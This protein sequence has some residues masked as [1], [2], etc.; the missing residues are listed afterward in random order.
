M[1]AHLAMIDS[2]VCRTVITGGL[3][4]ENTKADIEKLLKTHNFQNRLSI[5][6][7]SSDL[8]KLSTWINDNFQFPK[9]VFDCTLSKFIAWIIS[10]TLEERRQVKLVVTNKDISHDNTISVSNGK[11]TLKVNSETYLKSGF[12]FKHSIS[13]QGN[14][15]L[16]SQMYIHTFD[17]VNLEVNIQKGSKNDIRL[18]WFAENINN[19][20]FRF[21]FAIEKDELVNEVLNKIQSQEILAK[22]EIAKPLIQCM[23]NCKCPDLSITNDEDLLIEQLEWLSYASISGKQI[24]SSVDPYISRFNSLIDIDSTMDLGVITLDKTLISSNTVSRIFTQMEN[25]YQWFSIS[26]Y[27]VKNVTRSYDNGGEHC[28]V[29]DGTNDI[30]IHVNT[31]KFSLWEITDCGDPH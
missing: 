28:F 11:L 17:M 29:D 31:G 13:S 4:N 8:N 22:K 19:E 7:R 30:V 15:K 10:L 1:Q 23:K 3:V 25:Q 9:I 6:A 27:G 20:V 26:C 18:L 12:N 24:S 5:L 16:H 21:A 2:K 14:K